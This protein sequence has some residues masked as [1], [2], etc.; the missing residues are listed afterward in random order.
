[1]IFEELNESLERS[2]RIAEH[3]AS[4]KLNDLKDRQKDLAFAYK[5]KYWADKADSIHLF[6]K[7]L[8]NCIDSLK[9]EVK[10][11]VDE[12]LFLG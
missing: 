10:K 6:S 3:S 7:E 4:L 12:R 2:N 11:N 9:K 8:L 1:M 5:A